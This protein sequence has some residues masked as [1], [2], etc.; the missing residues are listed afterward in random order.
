MPEDCTKE[1]EKG[2]IAG[3]SRSLLKKC[4]IKTLEFLLE[5]R[6]SIDLHSLLSV[7]CVKSSP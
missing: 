2:V 7:F 3:E 5:P 6:K 4:T 1:I